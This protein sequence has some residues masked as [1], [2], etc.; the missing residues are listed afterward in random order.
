MVYILKDAKNPNQNKVKSLYDW[1]LTLL[2]LAGGK[3]IPP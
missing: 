1:K 2:R 3:Y